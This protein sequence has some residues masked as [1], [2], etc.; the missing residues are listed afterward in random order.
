MDV[1]CACT[2]FGKQTI[3]SILDEMNRETAPLDEILH[4]HERLCH[5]ARG[6]R[7]CKFCSLD[8][9]AVSS[10]IQGLGR[11]SVLY[12]GARKSCCRFGAGDLFGHR[13]VPASDAY[14]PQTNR[15]LD[16]TNRDVGKTADG[17]AMDKAGV[18]VPMFTPEKDYKPMIGL[19]RLALLESEAD[20]VAVTLIKQGLSQIGF[21][22]RDLQSL[23]AEGKVIEQTAQDRFEMHRIL[24]DRI[25][26]DIYSSLA[27]IQMG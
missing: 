26:D 25:L 27:R 1:S 19:G 22:L 5:L 15:Q 4:D 10:V 14:P 12:E 6:V 16:A 2:G 21:L 18:D 17:A 8:D 20:L 3:Q 7:N 24:I 13:G 9:S 11:L 23:L